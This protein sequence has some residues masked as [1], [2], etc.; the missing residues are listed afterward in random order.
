MQWERL[1]K[2]IMSPRNKQTWRSSLIYDTTWSP[3]PVTIH[4]FYCH[5][6]NFLFVELLFLFPFFFSPWRRFVFKP[7]Y[8]AICLNIY[9]SVLFFCLLLH[10][11]DVR[12]SL[13]FHVFIYTCTLGVPWVQIFTIIFF[14]LFKL[15]KR[16][17]YGCCYFFCLNIQPTQRPHYANSMQ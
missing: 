11:L 7:K 10:H 8:W 15:Q 2:H 17:F 3:I 16:L 4:C 9:F 14:C 13:P 5:I 12:I 6:F 1:E